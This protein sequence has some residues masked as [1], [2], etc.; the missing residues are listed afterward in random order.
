MSREYSAFIFSFQ[1]RIKWVSTK[2]I[3]SKWALPAS[4]K[5]LWELAKGLNAL[6]TEIWEYL[7]EPFLKVF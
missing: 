6:L 3:V 4:S 2:I 5:G 7:K 1:T